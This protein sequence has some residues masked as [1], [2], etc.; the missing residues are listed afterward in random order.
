MSKMFN[1]NNNNVKK[2]YCKVCHD[3]GKSESE[4]TSHW[5]KDRNN[6][7]TCPT[8]L[9]NEC[10]YCFK[11]GHTAKFC[12]VLKDKNIKPKPEPKSKPELKPKPEEMKSKSKPENIKPKSGFAILADDNSESESEEVVKKV[13][14]EFPVLSKPTGTST[15]T[16]TST[17]KSWAAMA[18]KPKIV[19]VTKNTINPKPIIRTNANDPSGRDYTKE[20]YTRNWADWSESEDEED[21]EDESESQAYPMP[22]TYKKAVD[23]FADYDPY[24]SYW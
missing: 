2:P 16:S 5:V 13:N 1:N 15:S 8:L 7:V 20:I 11:K 4:Y 3:A 18:A 24:D 21:Y 10:R 22:S 23:A 6:N 9:S 14:D 17:S 19:P 12:P